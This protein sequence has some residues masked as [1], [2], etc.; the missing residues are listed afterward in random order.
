MKVIW[1]YLPKVQ[2]I[3]VNKGIVSEVAN[4]SNQYDRK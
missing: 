3:K 4:K 2:G 1:Y